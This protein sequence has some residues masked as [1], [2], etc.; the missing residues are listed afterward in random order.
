[1]RRDYTGLQKNQMQEDLQATLTDLGLEFKILT[2]FTSFVAVDEQT[3]TDGN[4]PKRVEVPVAAPENGEFVENFWRRRDSSNNVSLN[5]GV[6]SATV[7]PTINGASGVT[8]TVEVTAD[9][10]VDSTETKLVTNITTQSLQNLP[11]NGRSVQSLLST[12]SGITQT[13]ES[14]LFEK[15]GIISSNGQRPT[16]NEFSV[17]GLS[18]NLGVSTDETS[19]SKTSVYCRR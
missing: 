15:R 19:L 8:A 11:I 18:A 1:M 2:P 9:A 10:T 4:Q 13:N 12:A 6:S 5:G 14:P 17:D 3:I 7:P 16:S